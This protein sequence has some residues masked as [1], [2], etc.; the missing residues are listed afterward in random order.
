[1]AEAKPKYIRKKY[2]LMEIR[3]FKNLPLLPYKYPT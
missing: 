2:E 3:Q 1:M